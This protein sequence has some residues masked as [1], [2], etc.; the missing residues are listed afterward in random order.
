MTPK[1][2]SLSR[3]ALLSL[4]AL[5]LGAFGKAA[6]ADEPMTADQAEAMAQHNREWAAVYRNAG[7]PA[8]KSGLVQR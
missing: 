1:N 2:R 8:Y 6:R 3:L 7:G 4:G 5:L